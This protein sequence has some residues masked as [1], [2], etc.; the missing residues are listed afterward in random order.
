[1]VFFLIYSN[2]IQNS[3][4]LAEQTTRRALNKISQN[5]ATRA[6]SAQKKISNKSE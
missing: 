4:K 3:R 2:Y 1:M 6:A 5:M